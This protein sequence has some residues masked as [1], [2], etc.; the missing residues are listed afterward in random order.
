MKT[1]KSYGTLAVVLCA[2]G[3]N[4]YLIICKG[5]ERQKCVNDKIQGGLVG[6]NIAYAGRFLGF[7][8]EIQYI[9]DSLLVALCLLIAQE[10]LMLTVS[11]LLAL[12]E[13]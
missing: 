9:W 8:N 10:W 1:G 11:L 6:E 5:I 3:I 4:K 2:Q 7:S 12:L 13:M